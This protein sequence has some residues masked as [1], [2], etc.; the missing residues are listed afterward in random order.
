MNTP[1]TD[2]L[3]L[4][5]RGRGWPTEARDRPFDRL[6]AADTALLE[7]D[8]ARLTR[9]AA[10]LYVD[11]VTAADTITARW[12]ID[13]AFAGSDSPYTTPLAF[14]GLELYGMTADGSWRWAGCL[15]PNGPAGGEGA[16]SRARLD[17]VERRYR[18]YLPLRSRVLSCEISASRDGDSAAIHAVQ[19][20]PPSPHETR[21]RPVCYYGTSIVHGVGVDR[22][23]MAHASQL[24]RALHRE[25]INLG[26][27]G[28]AR[29][30]TEIAD[31]LGRLDP[32]LFVFDVLPNNSADEVRSRVPAFVKRIR[33]H[34]P[35]TPILLLGDREFGDFVFCPERSS[36]KIAKDAA[37]VEVSEA[38]RRDNCSHLFLSLHENWFGRDAEGTVDASHPNSLGAH[39]F[40]SVLAELIRPLMQTHKS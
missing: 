29:C 18:L 31:A 5:L 23:G 40:A 4:G 17:G 36:T 12:R 15:G 22:P 37:L 1:W 13:D 30:E 2:V 16:L 38:L 10:G 28:R 27:A 8:L 33:N 3:T 20:G 35:E 24:D 7:P 34:H 11:F 19:A 21:E 6:P 14:A 32:A 9:Q 26:V 25:V 39:R